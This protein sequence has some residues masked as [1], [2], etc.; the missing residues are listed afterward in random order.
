MFVTPALENVGPT[1][2]GDAVILFS[3]TTTPTADVAL[4]KEVA[5]VSVVR[6]F[7]GL[8]CFG[9]GIIRFADK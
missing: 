3:S 2:E 5:A 7:F 9:L 4:V 1:I 8:W 6:V